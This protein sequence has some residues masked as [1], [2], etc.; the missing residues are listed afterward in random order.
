MELYDLKWPFGVKI[1]IASVIIFPQNIHGYSFW[2]R[3]SK[4][5]HITLQV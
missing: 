4:A 2:K 5:H 3:C 1:F